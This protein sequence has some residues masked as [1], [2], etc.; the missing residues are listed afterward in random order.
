MINPGDEVEYYGEITFNGDEFLGVIVTDKR[1]YLTDYDFY[2][3][4][5]NDD[6]RLQDTLK[7]EDSE[8]E[9]QNFF[10][11]EVINNLKK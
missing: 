3:V 8:S 1:G 10:Q 7:S 6:V 9:I 11:E 2:S 4:L 5:S